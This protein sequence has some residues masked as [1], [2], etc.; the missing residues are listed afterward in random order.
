[1]DSPV[2]IANVRV[3]GNSTVVVLPKTVREHLG[4]V[5]R[6]VVGFRRVGRYWILRRLTPG[7]LMPVTDQEA[8]HAAAEV[9]R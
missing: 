3:W 6:D 5:A 8:A 9:D 4:V 7:D 1:M 2:L